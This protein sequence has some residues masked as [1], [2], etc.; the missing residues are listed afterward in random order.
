VPI[1]ATRR[2][3]T[4]TSSGQREVCQDGPRKSAMPSMSGSLGRLRNPTAV[5]TALL[6][7]VYSP[8]GP[9]T[10]TSHSPASSSQVSERTSVSKTMSSLRPNSSATHWKYAWFSGPVQNGLGYG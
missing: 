9:S 5:N 2:P 10:V 3:V 6:R 4:S 8:S 7:T 1:V